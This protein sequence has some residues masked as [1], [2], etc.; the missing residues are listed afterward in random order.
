LW[1]DGETRRVRV[2]DGAAMLL[3]RRLTV[4]LMVQPDV[5]GI[6]LSDR[7]LADQG[8][9]FSVPDNCARQR[10][11]P[12]AMARARAGYRCSAQKVRRAVT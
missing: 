2:G 1:D 10:C 8:L 9:S 6:M 7:L 5:A 12:A 3:G 11:R 4:H